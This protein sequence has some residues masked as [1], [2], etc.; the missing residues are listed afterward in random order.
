M[1]DSTLTI[2]DHLLSASILDLLSVFDLRAPACTCSRWR[3]AVPAQLSQLSCIV[4]SAGSNEVMLFDTRGRL[5]ASFCALP[6]R[7]PRRRGHKGGVASAWP[8]DDWP[9][10]LAL[11][12]RGEL[13]VSQYRVD[14][15]LQFKRTA[16]LTNGI[17][18]GYAYQRTVAAGPR[19]VSPE[20]VV[21]AHDSLYL[22]SAD[23]G[24]IN[25][26]SVSPAGRVLAK[27]VP[28][29]HLGR[30]CAYWGMT[31]GP[32]GHLYL[33]AHV[34]DGVHYLQPT[35]HDTGGVL[36]QRLAPNGDF[37]G[38]TEAWAGFDASP[39]GGFAAGTALNRPSAPAFCKHGVL[40]V[41][42]FVTGESAELLKERGAW[43]AVY[44]FASLAS[45]AGGLCVGWL[46]ASQGA[47]LL[48]H[49]WGVSF[50]PDGAGAFVCCQ[51]ADDQPPPEPLVRLEGCGCNDGSDA[52]VS[53][54][55]PPQLYYPLPQPTAFCCGRATA[56]CGGSARIK[57]ANYVVAL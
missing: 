51:A 15:L 47:G 20:G 22:V 34:N 9:T 57:S 26:L 39:G 52:L 45:L 36:R 31:L 53:P 29:E 24:V 23:L 41:S 35:A 25:R 27:S 17:P 4:T 18:D 28:F 21:H 46:E 43:R 10:C 48:D 19:F 37:D 3:N 2:P 40:H 11:G 5:A 8:G 33:A 1:V 13:F 7:K 55:P 49:V 56:L 42:S 12:P 14:G 54:G 16:T 6:P 30:S 32:D 44:K 38:L 50:A